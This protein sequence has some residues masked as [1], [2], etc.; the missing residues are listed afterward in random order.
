MRG[1]SDSGAFTARALTDARGEACL[2]FTGLPLAFPRSGGGV[3]HGTAAHVI[4]A[5]D[6][7]TALFHAPAE[8]EA[9]QR[10][11]A[12]RTSGHPDPDAF[13]DAAPAAFAAGAAVTL[14][15]GTTSGVALTWSP[16]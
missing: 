6:P 10:D 15:A 13:P 5:A 3:Q 4:V 1:R 2:I 14:A 12:N 7:A 9:A 8:L 16:A 11:A